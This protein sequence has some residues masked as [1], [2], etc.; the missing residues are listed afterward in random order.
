MPRVIMLA[1]EG[2]DCGDEGHGGRQDAGTAALCAVEG[3]GQGFQA[4]VH[5][6]D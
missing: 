5:D 1:C 6:G 3:D 2:Q 4:A